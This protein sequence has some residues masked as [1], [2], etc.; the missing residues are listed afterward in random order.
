MLVFR[1]RHNMGPPYLASDL[2]W[3]EEAE[4]LQ[5]LYFSSR[6]RLILPRT[7]LCT[8]GDR[9]FRV[10]AARAWNSLPD[11]VTSDR[12]QNTT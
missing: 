11:S 6:R 7:R 5:R 2:R 9:S 3:T 10:T 1:C 4:A 8:I 12:V